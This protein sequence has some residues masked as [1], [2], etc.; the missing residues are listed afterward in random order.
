MK[1]LQLVYT[2]W[3]EKETVEIS[4]RLDKKISYFCKKYGMKK[5]NFI[6]AAISE[7]LEKVRKQ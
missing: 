1:G 6:D 2:T 7:K 5:Q 3:D 4:K